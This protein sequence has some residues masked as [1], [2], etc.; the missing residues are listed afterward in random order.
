[1][2]FHELAVALS[3]SSRAIDSS[4]RRSRRRIGVNLKRRIVA[5]APVR[6]GEHQSKVRTIGN[7]RV[8]LYG[9]V[10]ALLDRGRMKDRRGR[11]NGSD[12]APDGWVGPVLERTES[13]IEQEVEKG[14]SSALQRRA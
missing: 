6:T 14:I 12:Q 5:A 9:D 8:E 11:M 13:A 4:M 7:D 10:A 2:T 3:A 1:M